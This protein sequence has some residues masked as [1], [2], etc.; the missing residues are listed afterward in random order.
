MKRHRIHPPAPQA[1]IPSLWGLPKNLLVCILDAMHLRDQE[2]LFAT[3]KSIRASLSPAITAPRRVVVSYPQDRL[4]LQ[5]PIKPP[6]ENLRELELVK[7]NAHEV[8][9]LGLAR[10]ALRGLRKLT[11]EFPDTDDDEGDNV[12]GTAMDQVLSKAPTMFAHLQHLDLSCH[13]N[14]SLSSA[15]AGQLISM[16]YCTLKR[17]GQLETLRLRHLCAPMYDLDQQDLVSPHLF[18]GLT[19]L[20][21]NVTWNNKL[22]DNLLQATS[23][24]LLRL[25]LQSDDNAPLDSHL[26]AMVKHWPHMQHFEL[27]CYMDE[28]SPEHWSRSSMQAMASWTDLRV[29]ALESDC[30]RADVGFSTQLFENL[31]SWPNLQTLIVTTEWQPTQTDLAALHRSCPRLEWIA[32]AE[33]TDDLRPQGVLTET[34]VLQFL[35]H[36]PFIPSVE[37]MEKCFGHRH[38]AYSPAMLQ[39]VLRFNTSRSWTAWEPTQPQPFDV[40]D[41]ERLVRECRQLSFARNVVLASE[42]IRPTF[43]EHVSALSKLEQLSLIITGKHALSLTSEQLKHLGRSCPRLC[44]LKLTAEDRRQRWALPPLSC[45]VSDV[46]DLLYICSDLEELDI[47][48]QPLAPLTNAD[49]R[50]L[51]HLLPLTKTADLQLNF[52]HL[53]VTQGSLRLTTEDEA[54]IGMVPLNQEHECRWFG[55]RIREIQDYTV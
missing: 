31:P 18:S 30:C 36:H 20:A 52:L 19:S 21:L 39:H 44:V 32:L 55:D 5:S 4:W 48:A 34:D 37:A 51:R 25:E 2:A 6:L 24:H 46:L 11:I 9:T 14:Q 3:A 41:F 27:G 23:T 43:W 42:S 53:V 40:D 1:L 35:E 33:S 22:F 16:L 17:P 38:D 10:G 50:R 15:A 49:V 12:I 8:Y 29:L 7:W 13:P 47:D 45:S 54:R 28:D 26:I